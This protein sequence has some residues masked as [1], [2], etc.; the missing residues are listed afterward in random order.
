MRTTYHALVGVV[1]H[2]AEGARVGHVA[3]LRAKNIRGR[4]R[5]A[6]LLVGESELVARFGIKVGEL[7]GRRA[8]AGYAIPWRLVATVDRERIILKVGKEKLE[9]RRD[10]RAAGD[11]P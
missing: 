10:F 4:L 6:E 3:D 7:I 9:R 5:V 8:L 11:R 2:D 1:V